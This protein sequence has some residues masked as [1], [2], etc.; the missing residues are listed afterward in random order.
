MKFLL[1]LMCLCLADDANS[2]LICSHQPI[3]VLAGDDVILP[4]H[5]EPP[6]S[7]SD[8]TVEWT[9]PDLDPK[10][11]HFHQDGRLMFDHQNPSYYLRT[12]LFMDG[13]MTGN[14]SM[15]IFKVKVSDTGRYQCALP[16]LQKEASIQLIVAQSDVIGSDKPVTVTVGD[17]A[18]LPCHLEPPSDMTTQTVEWTCDKTIVHVYRNRKDYL[19]LQDENFRGRTSVFHEEMI[20]GNISLKLTNVTEL[21]AGSFTCNV[22][23]L[24]SQVRRGFINLTVEPEESRNKGGQT[25]DIGGGTGNNT[26]V[27]T[28]IAFGVIAGIVAL[29]VLWMKRR[30]RRQERE[31]LPPQSDNAKAI[32][33]E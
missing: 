3:T 8:E 19:D 15:K 7:V 31:Y 17:N 14:V 10:Y 29:A 12:R 9:R 18:I 30:N 27:I 1:Q 25:D 24:Q 16:S 20:R 32:P 33:L 13:L 23:K 21:D 28:G 2:Q 26:G 5:L 6:I 4:C 11:I 22:P